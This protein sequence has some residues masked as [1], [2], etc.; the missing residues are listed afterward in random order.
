VVTIFVVVAYKKCETINNGRPS[1]KFGLPNTHRSD[2][3]RWRH[4]RVDRQKGDRKR[5]KKKCLQ[6]LYMKDL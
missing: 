6:T 2:E 1:G 5:T 4:N 3:G